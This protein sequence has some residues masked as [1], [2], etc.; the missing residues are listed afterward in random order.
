MNLHLPYPKLLN[1]TRQGILFN[2]KLATYTLNYNNDDN[3]NNM[4]LTQDKAL[5]HIQYILDYPNLDF[6]NAKNCSYCISVFINFD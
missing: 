6:P 3:N 2:R 5:H 1:K 4:V